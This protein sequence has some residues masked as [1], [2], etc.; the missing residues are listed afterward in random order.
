MALTGSEDT[1]VPR[2][3][4]PTMA[5][6]RVRA[7]IADHSHNALAQR[8]A[9]AAF[10]IR[11]ASAA[12][13][14]L[15]QVLLARWMGTFEFGVYVYVWTW[16]LLIGGLFDLGL[17]QSAQRFIPEYIERKQADELRGF[18]AGSRWLAVGVATAAAAVGALVILVVTPWL[19][20]YL[21]LPLFLA[22]LCLPLYALTGVQDGI[23][24]SYN[25]LHVA[26][27]PPFI[28]RPL[29]LLAFMAAAYTA[30]L[31]VN[32]QTAMLSSVGSVWLTAI[33]Q[34]LTLNG[35]LKEK[36]PAGPKTYQVR[37]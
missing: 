35:R 14:Y 12:L 19:D 5:L 4:S 27:V 22:C 8:M 9:G 25:W 26:L 10:M 11:V 21:V 6:A 18:I 36:V 30:G 32:A 13:L 28:L 24:R 17:A 37:H 34:L 29:L 20:H 3:L 15:S 7:W 23:G 31:P 16:V 1:R 2:R 33:L